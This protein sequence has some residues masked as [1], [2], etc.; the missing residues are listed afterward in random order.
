MHDH[1]WRLAILRS[2]SH[3][4]LQRRWSKFASPL[5]VFALLQLPLP[6]VATHHRVAE[7]IDAIGEVLAGHA[8]HAAFPVLQVA[9]VNAIPILNNPTVVVQLYEKGYG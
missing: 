8:D 2:P 9:L 6:E 3:F 1:L 5:Q 4:L 7:L